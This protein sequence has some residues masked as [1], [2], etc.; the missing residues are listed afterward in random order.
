LHRP[1]LLIWLVL[2][3]VMVLLLP[4][5]VASTTTREYSFDLGPG[6]D[7]VDVYV[8]LYEQQWAVVVVAFNES[9][10]SADTKVWPLAHYVFPTKTVVETVARFEGVQYVEFTLSWDNATRMTFFLVRFIVRV[11]FHGQVAAQVNVS[12]TVYGEVPSS[13]TRTDPS[14]PI[15]QSGAIL[16][17]VTAGAAMVV[18]LTL[19]AAVKMKRVRIVA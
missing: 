12:V 5:Q 7:S 17:M 19:V 18:A 13:D 4:G 16:P 11:F 3:T 8:Y 2:V 15:D 14:D 1:R 10:E 6:D 9:A